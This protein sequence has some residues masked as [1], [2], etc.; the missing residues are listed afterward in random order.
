MFGLMAATKDE[1]LA[2]RRIPT[3]ATKIE[4]PDGLAVA[5]LYEERNAPCAVAFTGTA[6]KP[7]FNFKFSSAADRTEQIE[8]YFA[9]LTSNANSKRAYR[10]AASA[11]HSLKV[12]D[13]LSG[14]WGYE[15]T[16]VEFYQVVAVTTHGATLR[17][18]ADETVPDSTVSHGMADLRTAIRDHFCG[19][20]VRVRV[21]SYNRCQVG[22]CSLSPWDG[23]PCYC[24]W[25][26]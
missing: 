22:S 5:Y 21:S 17:S 12:G 13:I 19:E 3:G 26:A 20:P 4:H 7:A 10:A 15:Q 6:A 9:N 14:S 18:I 11:P 24:S 25:Y 16:N 2:A 23:K 1:R 8:T